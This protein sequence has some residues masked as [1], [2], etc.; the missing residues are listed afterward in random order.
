MP[1]TGFE[2]G[3]LLLAATQSSID[4]APVKGPGRPDHEGH[5]A[6]TPVLEAGHPSTLFYDVPP[7][8]EDFQPLI[9][10]HRRERI[11][12][13]KS[14]LIGAKARPT[15][16][17][18]GGL[19]VSPPPNFQSVEKTKDAIQALVQRYPSAAKRAV[20][21]L[22][23]RWQAWYIAGLIQRLRPD[24]CICW[25]GVRGRSRLFMDVA[26]DLGHP[27]I[28]M[29]ESPVPGCITCDLGGVNYE[30]S[31]PRRMDFYHAW[32]ADSGLAPKA[33]MA[34]KDALAA[35][36]VQRSHAVQENRDIGAEGNFI[37]FPLQ[38]PTDSQVI[39]FG[40][41]YRTMHA[42]VEELIAASK[43][44]PDGW[45]LR[46]K[47]HPSSD[48]LLG[49]MIEPHVGAKLR[50]DNRT[51]TFLQVQ[52]AHSVLTLNSSV[53]I[54]A[55]YFG[56]PVMTLGQAFWDFGGLAEH[57]PTA[58][59]VLRALSDPLQ[60]GFSEED[61]DAFMNYLTFEYYV[62]EQD[63]ADGKVHVNDIIASAGR[64]DALLR[65]IIAED[66]KTG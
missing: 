10:G 56:K 6:A 50:L 32:Q 57:L 62:L 42:Y 31:L 61:R 20:K 17:P 4:N 2:Y 51:D 28:Y 63:V 52:A 44:L 33:W 39:N 34:R 49:D 45:H 14:G 13:L 66:Q 1:M 48:V 24:I 7:V 26:R 60:I 23:Y 25:G 8:A 47:E 22:V 54:Q 5:P 43:A 3:K 65:R 40:G 21:S 46:I 35:R 41:R 38:V 30:N 37:F 27:K 19:R 59:A 16:L 64:R 15:H 12:N 11:N 9:H 58:E 36:V 18:K 55:F 29:E 53:G